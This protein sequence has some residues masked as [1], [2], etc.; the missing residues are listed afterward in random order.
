MSVFLI[1]YDLRSPGRDYKNLYDGIR[2]LG[3]SVRTLESVWVV[4]S[5]SSVTAV[6][7]A[8]ARHMDKNDGLLVVQ[9]ARNAAWRSVDHAVALKEMLET[10]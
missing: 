9:T 4:H 2:R 1:S 6:R 7:D 5:S 10:F 8:L 3:K